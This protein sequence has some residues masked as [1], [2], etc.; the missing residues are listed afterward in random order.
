MPIENYRAAVPVVATEDVA[1]TVD[2][3]VQTLGFEQDWTWGDPPIYAG[4]KAGDVLLYINYDPET[5]VAIQ[6]AELA[7]E[8]FLWVSEIES[9]YEQHLANG[10]EI[11]E[12]LSARPWGALQYVVRDPNGYW[13]K[14]AED[15]EVE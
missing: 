14:I 12:E 9:V 2:Y 3:F 11:V 1:G 7:P 10:A 8:I 15:V 13:L 5:A 6:Q 4:L